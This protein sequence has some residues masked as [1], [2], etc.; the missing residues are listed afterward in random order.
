MAGATGCST[1]STTS[2][3]K[4]LLSILTYYCC[5]SGSYAYWIRSSS[6][7]GKPLEIRS[8]NDP[9][10]ISGTCIAWAARQGIGL[11]HIQLANSQQN[12]YIEGYDWMVRYNWLKSLPV[13]VNK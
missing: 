5:Q 13:R 12:A 8:D 3:G 6:G 9:E 7:R 1:S 2:T 4:P 11:D 10:C